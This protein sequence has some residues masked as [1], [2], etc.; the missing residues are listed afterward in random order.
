MIGPL[1]NAVQL[2]AYGAVDQSRVALVLH[3][4]VDTDDAVIVLLQPSKLLGHMAT[5]SIRDLEVTPADN[6]IHL[7]LLEGVGCECSDGARPADLVFVPT[8]AC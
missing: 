2:D 3:L 6:N 1:E 4:H 8:A 7:F 5:E